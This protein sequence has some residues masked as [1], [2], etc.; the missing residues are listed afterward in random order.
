MRLVMLFAICHLGFVVGIG[1][2]QEKRPVPKNP[3]PSTV[4]L[5]E[6]DLDKGSASLERVIWEAQFDQKT[7]QVTKWNTKTICETILL[8]FDNLSVFE[9]GNDKPL[10]KEIAVKRL[11]VGT[12]L[13]T[14]P[15]KK[16][17]DPYY[18]PFYKPGTLVLVMSKVP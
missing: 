3:P 13:L 10:S 16:P 2:A 12:P 1:H 11:K 18:V 14:T 7:M 17:L 9:V 5:A 4:F 15:D 6:V 8:D